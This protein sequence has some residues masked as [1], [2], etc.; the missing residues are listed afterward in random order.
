MLFVDYREGSKELVAPLK[1]A[2]LPVEETD[3]G[4]GEQGPVADLAFTG[5]GE[6]GKSVEVGVEF[7]KVGELVASLRSERL[8]GEQ[9]PAMRRHYDFCWLLYE[10]EILHNRSGQLLRRTGRNSFR[11]L[12]GKMSIGEFEKRVLVLHLC[13]GLNPR[14]TETRRDTIKW[15]EALYRTWTDEDLD[16]HKSHLGIYQPPTPIPVSEF[17]EVVI[18]H[19]AGIGFRASKIV[20]ERFHGSVREAAN[21]TVAQWAAIDLPD[22]NGKIRRLGTTRAEQIVQ[23]FNGGMRR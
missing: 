21:A 18:K 16:Q 14:H 8:Q 6:G 23:F 20:E 22:K 4:A 9:L 13:G 17:R 11:P 3:L 7:K 12:P 5:R 19:C 15:I 2:G 10:G 1:A